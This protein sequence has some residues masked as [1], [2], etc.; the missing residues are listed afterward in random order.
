MDNKAEHLAEQVTQ[1][2]AGLA[3]SAWASISWWDEHSAGVV[4]IAAAVGAAC[5]V[6]G[7]LTSLYFK[8]KN[9]K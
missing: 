5:S 9:N 3:V 2:G 4:G 6:A 8:S 7:Y 1:A